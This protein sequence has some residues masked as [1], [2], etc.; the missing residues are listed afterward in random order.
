M[1]HTDNKA[2]LI[3]AIDNYDAY[4]KSQRKI[5][6]AFVGLAVNDIIP[7]KVSSLSEMLQISRFS[8]YSALSCLE[9]D[10]AIIKINTTGSKLPSFKLN[11]DKLQL[12]EET[13]I[14]KQKYLNKIHD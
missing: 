3:E 5:L 12:I 13:Y 10:R 7:I 6:S 14:Q 1:N 11:H 4:T 8:V 2:L 9:K